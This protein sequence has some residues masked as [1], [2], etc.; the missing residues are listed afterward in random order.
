[1]PDYLAGTSGRLKVAATTIDLTTDTVTFT[2]LTTAVVAEITKW[3][4]ISDKFLGEAPKS[5]TLES[6]ANAE[7]VLYPDAVRGGMAQWSCPVEFQFNPA[8]ANKFRVGAFFIADFLV[9]K[10]VSAGRT[11]CE[12]RVTEYQQGGADVQTGVQMGSC[13]LEGFGPLPAFA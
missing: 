6:R 5:S 12:C 10:N 8:N 7:G 4:P 9:K 2:G 1:M 3:G 11:G 13:V